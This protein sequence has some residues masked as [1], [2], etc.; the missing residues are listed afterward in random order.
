MRRIIYG[1]ATLLIAIIVVFLL[2]RYVTDDNQYLPS[3]I[4]NLHLTEEQTQALLINRMKVFGVYGPL[5]Q[6]L[7]N[8][9]KNIFPLIPKT[10]VIDQL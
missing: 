4:S 8:Y 3:N 7:A 10:V 2:V 5:G 6:Q 1:L 9:L